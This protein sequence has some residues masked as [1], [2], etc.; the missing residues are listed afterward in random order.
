MMNPQVKMN[1]FGGSGT[2]LPPQK[3]IME[4]ANVSDVSR[5]DMSD[6][7]DDDDDSGSGSD[8]GSESGSGSE[9]CSDIGSSDDSD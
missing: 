1:G 6:D 9:G 3:G 5:N 7:D 2:P 8:S 4:K